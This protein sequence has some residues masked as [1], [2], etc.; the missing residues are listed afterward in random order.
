MIAS[1]TRLRARRLVGF[2]TAGLVL[3]LGAR[4]LAPAPA[5][6]ELVVYVG[7]RASAAEIQL[8][9]DEAV[10]VEAA[11]ALGLPQH[12]PF[13]RARVVDELRA[14]DPQATAM[15]DDAL[16]ERAR[17]LGLARAHP[18]LRARIAAAM[19]RR[20]VARL[21]PPDDATLTEYLHAHAERYAHAPRLDL[22]QVMIG[23]PSMLPREVTRAT[24]TQI[25]ATFGPQLAAAAAAAVPGAWTGPVRSSYGVHWL[26]VRA[27]EPG[28]MPELA[29]VRVRLAHDWAHDRARTERAA[30][31]AALREAHAITIERAEAPR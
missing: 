14:A 8:A 27:R 18:L 5:P 10:L 21:E 9:I 19:E 28:G 15:D 30:R 1:S 31:L 11:F 7:A 4:V 3:W 12:D 25:E 26:H 2:A 6:A 20:L 22:E 13:V 17:Q 23:A 16:F 24:P 29:E